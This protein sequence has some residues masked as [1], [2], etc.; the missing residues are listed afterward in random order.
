LSGKINCSYLRRNYIIIVVIERLKTYTKIL[1][2]KL[3]WMEKH[4][5]EK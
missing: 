5:K 1:G 3:F 4:N 2:V